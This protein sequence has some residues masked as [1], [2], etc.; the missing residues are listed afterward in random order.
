MMNLF[1]SLSNRFAP[2][3]EVTI[4]PRPQSRFEG[5]DQAD[6]I[7]EEQGFETA[8]AP[9]THAAPPPHG[10]LLKM[11][12]QKPATTLPS[13]PDAP[14]RT[15]PSD[16]ANPSLG[17][18]A[19]NPP[20]PEQPLPQM[21]ETLPAS[22]PTPSKPL[23]SHQQTKVAQ[24]PPA[25][26]TDKQSDAITEIHH[27]T[28]RETLAVASPAPPPL[29]TRIAPKTAPQETP[30]APEPVAASSTIVRIGKV[31][32]RQPTPPPAPAPAPP[33]RAATPSPGAAPRSTTNS[34]GKGSG[35]TD[36]LGW[37]RR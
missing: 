6:G 12:D 18:V 28:T 25:R 5:H 3:A 29:Q 9:Q 4:R 8:A 33:R 17:S 26:P 36:Y 11:Q 14:P 21:P 32:I 23:E 34:G 27:E 24:T 10:P 22:Q 20:R 7:S 2:K 35:L 15:A 16:S 19:E 31:E 13:P 37:K 30:A 1:D